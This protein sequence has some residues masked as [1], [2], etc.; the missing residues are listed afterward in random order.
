MCYNWSAPTFSD[1][2]HFCQYK[3]TIRQK[4]YIFLSFNS[5]LFSLFSFP[6]SILS[7]FSFLF[8]HF[9][10]LSVFFLYFSLFFFSLFYTL[11]SLSFLL[12]ERTPGVSP[13]IFKYW[14]RM[15]YLYYICMLFTP[16]LF[17]ALVAMMRHYWSSSN[18]SNFLRILLI[19]MP[20][21]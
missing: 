12:S 1:F 3:E 19:L 21:A 15:M 11:S 16:S 9:P 14:N 17:G 2:E 10:S 5:S 6:I 18:S 20:N 7:L 4:R 13:I 8:S